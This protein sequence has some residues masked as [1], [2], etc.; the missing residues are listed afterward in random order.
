[1]REKKRKFFFFFKGDSKIR[2]EESNSMKDESA[3]R[4]AYR[5]T[6]AEV[7]PWLFQ[8]IQRGDGFGEFTGYNSFI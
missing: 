3:K 6:S 7:Q 2:K 1:M 5:R 4:M 8:G